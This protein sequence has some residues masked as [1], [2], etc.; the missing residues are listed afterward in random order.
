MKKRIVWGLVL[1]LLIVGSVAGGGRPATGGGSTELSVAWW[2]GDARHNKTLAMIDDHMKRYPD[3]R[4]V[5]Q[6]APYTDYFARLAT[7]VA[8][9]NMPDVFLVQLTYLADYA[10][11]GLMRPLQDLIDA[12]KI[13]VKN[14][15]NGALSGSSYNG[16]VVGITL[17]DTTGCLVY[18]KSFL[19]RIGHPLPTDSMSYSEFGQYLKTMV[20][21]L[22]RG[23]VA[24]ILNNNNETA[25]ENYARNYGRYGITSEDGKELGYTREILASYYNFYYDLFQNGVSGTMQQILDDK[26]V[27]WGDSLSGKGQMAVWFTNVNQGKIFQAS[28]DDE[29][30]MTRYPIADNATNKYIEAAVCSTWGI[31]GRSTKVD[32][33]ARFISDMVNNWDLQK[34]YDMDIGV[35]GSTLIQE[36]LISE[37][38]L[39]NKVDILKKREIELMQDIL[40]TIEPFNGRASNTGAVLGD[41]QLKL[42]SVFQ[43]DM[44]VQQAVDAHFAAAITLLQ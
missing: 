25:I 34:I 41:M 18:N 24:F 7:L 33:A 27:Q 32:Q 2:G 44:T 9:Q 42:D 28:V 30:G 29:L 22:P 39:S 23:S 10:S 21:K 13:D 20:P 15:T 3:V 1:V 19:E 16:K 11:R 37:L 12:G 6:Y 5:S 4:V 31:S 14:F 8:A 36:K 26:N 40:N 43:G 38:D 35:P 17:G